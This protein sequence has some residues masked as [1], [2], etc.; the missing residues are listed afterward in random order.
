MD[1]TKQHL[2]AVLSDSDPAARRRAAEEL[3][4]CTGFAPIAALAAALR[5]ENKGVR[6]AALR[7]LSQIGNKNV[8]RAVVEYLADPN[9]TTRNLAAELLMR[10][11][12]ESLEALLPYLYDADQD[13]RKF[14]VDILGANGS[15]DAIPHL[16]KLLVDPDENVVISA[17]EALGNVRSESAIPALTKAFNEIGYAKATAAEAIGKI[18]GTKATDFLLSQISTHIGEPGSDPLVLYALLEAISLIGYDK[19]FYELCN[20]LAGVKGKLRRILLHAIIRIGERCTIAL[21]RAQAVKTDLID[22]LKDRNC[23]IQVSAVKGLANLEGDDVTA[24]LVEAVNRSEECDSVLTP[25]LEYRGGAFQVMVNLL[26]AGTITPTKEVISLMGKL[27]SHIEYAAIPKELIE[28]D[29]RLLQRAFDAVKGA[30][31]DATEELRAVIVDTLFRLDG[32]QAVQVLDAIVDEPDPWLRIH[33]IELLSPLN[34]RR[35]PQFIG[36]FLEDED[37]MVRDVAASTLAGR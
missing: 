7:S 31:G 33:V 2:A 25:I 21:D 15:N 37:E 11:R 9:I 19:A 3:A 23:S 10:L 24:A 6:D 28:S 22:A 29:G 16:I 26:E 8:A 30:W 13:V 12:E 4:A 20:H 1:E 17:V 34:D 35:I 36:R 14:V 27:V 18:G 5:D 32:D